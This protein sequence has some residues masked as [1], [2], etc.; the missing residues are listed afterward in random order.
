MLH[1][2]DDEE[3]EDESKF[4]RFPGVPQAKAVAV[5]YSSIG[6]LAG[7]SEITAL[8]RGNFEIHEICIRLPEIATTSRRNSINSAAKLAERSPGKLA[9]INKFLKISPVLIGLL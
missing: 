1:R 6:V 8:P 4:L 5:R 2:K 3:S 9:K 7:S